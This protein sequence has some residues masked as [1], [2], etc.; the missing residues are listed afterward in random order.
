MKMGRLEKLFVN[1]ERNAERVIE[2]AET[3]L[4][5]VDVSGKRDF[6][7]VGCG[8]GAMCLHIAEKYRL[9]VT[10]VDVDPGQLSLA[11]RKADGAPNVRFTEAD[12]TTLPFGDSEFDIVLAQNV[13]HHVYDW[14]DALEQMNR[15]MR[16][17]GYLIYTDLVYPEWAARL[18]SSGIG[19]RLARA[20]GFPTAAGLSA[21]AERN[22]F[23]TMHA[24]L[25]AKHMLVFNQYH[26]VYRKPS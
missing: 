5:H 10:G 19:A 14:L 15:V 16:P 20:Y 23:S 25:S 24:V 9:N 21:F 7:E 2:R 11:R 3:L 6:L 8:S 17:G 22:G 4:S 13:L 12:V 26:A 1:S 18:G